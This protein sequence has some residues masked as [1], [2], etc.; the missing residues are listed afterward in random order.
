MRPS[1]QQS[2][3]SDRVDLRALQQPESDFTTISSYTSWLH[4]TAA[5]VSPNLF[6]RFTGFAQAP[7]EN[8]YKP[9]I[10]LLFPPRPALWLHAV[11]SSVQIPASLRIQ[12]AWTC[13][14]A[15][16]EAAPLPFV[17]THAGLRLNNSLVNNWRGENYNTENLTSKSLCS[18]SLGPRV[19][20]HSFLLWPDLKQGPATSQKWEFS[21]FPQILRFRERRLQLLHTPTYKAH[22]YPTSFFFCFRTDLVPGGLRT[23]GSISWKYLTSKGYQSR[24][25]DIEHHIC[26]TN[27]P[28]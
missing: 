6:S 18:D 2:P 19:T 11:D 13:L 9:Q 7:L 1:G 27:N 5:W 15:R 14:P 28:H 22:P 12:L 16:H 10:V 17:I 3:N 21:W 26:D 20:P 24:H 4:I 25:P 8:S 23:E